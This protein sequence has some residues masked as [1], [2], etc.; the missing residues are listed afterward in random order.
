MNDIDSSFLN[1]ND[2]TKDEI[3]E[4]PNKKLNE[5]PNIEIPIYLNNMTINEMIKNFEVK[6]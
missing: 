1:Y 3:K 6:K 2:E 5:I 4:K